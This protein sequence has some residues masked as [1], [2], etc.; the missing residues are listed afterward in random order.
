MNQLLPP[1][2]LSVVSQLAL[3]P[4]AFS[5][6]AGLCQNAL[7]RLG[8]CR[9]KRIPVSRSKGDIPTSTRGNVVSLPP[10]PSNSPCSSYR[11]LPV[12]S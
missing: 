10:L 4:I 9:E 6:T 2:R 11:L 8:Y 1:T 3:L 5:V 12:G 7:V